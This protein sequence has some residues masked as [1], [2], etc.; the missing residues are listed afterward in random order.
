MESWLVSQN[1]ELAELEVNMNVIARIAG[2]F[3]QGSRVRNQIGSVQTHVSK[4]EEGGAMV[5]MA[6]VLPILLLIFTGI[7]SFGIALNN[8]IM[9]TSSVEVGGRQLAIIRGNTTDPCHDVSATIAAASPLLKSANLK[10]TFVLNGTTYANTTTCT[11]GAAQVVE[12][13]PMQVLVSYPCSLLVYS[14]NVLPGCTLTAQAT[15][16]EQ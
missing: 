2:F 7:T 10:Y 15:E 1:Y 12:S 4:S 16:L 11:A 5:E 13:Q 6:L 3:C 9:L 8:Y 14:K